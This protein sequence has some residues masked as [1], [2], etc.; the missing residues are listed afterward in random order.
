MAGHTPII[1]REIFTEAGAHPNKMD[2]LPIA[3]LLFLL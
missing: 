1:I 3:A 2:I